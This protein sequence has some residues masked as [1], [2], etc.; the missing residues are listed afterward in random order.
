[1]LDQVLTTFGLTPDLDL[2]LMQPRQDLT[3]V[4][5]R[6]LVELR[7]IFERVQP[8]WVLVQG[9]TTTA[10]ASALASYYAQIKVG[11]IEAGL[12][13]WNK[14]APFPEEVNRRAIALVAEVY[15]A[16][17]AQ[18]Q[19][20]LLAEQVPAERIYITGNTGIDALRLTRTRLMDDSFLRAE[21]VA[22]MAFLCEDKKLILV[23]THRRE[24]FCAFEEICQAIRDLSLTRQDIQIL[25]P[26]HL[27]PRVRATVEKIL[28][29]VHP[30]AREFPMVHAPDTLENLFLVDPL[31]YPSFVFTLDRA[32]LVLTDSGGI[33][34]EAASLGKPC[35]ILRDTTE[36]PEA[37]NE[38]STR[39]VGTTHSNILKHTL[40]LLDDNAAY[41][42]M[43]RATDVFGDG[44]AAEKIVAALRHLAC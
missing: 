38:G 11:H 34:E 5:A 43:A 7:T 24:N 26:V 19:A 9:D 3:D 13:T 39:L 42:Q 32:F 4:T 21:V 6:V 2:D 22:R 31:D 16:P 18:A 17:T 20:H 44:H 41:N 8:E 14:Y 1:M 30:V 37:L 40:T 12:R 23:T 29:A 36:R 10:F 15:F 27:N 25:F 33:Q 28:G 35:L